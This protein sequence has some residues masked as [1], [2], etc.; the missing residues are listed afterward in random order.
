MLRKL[1]DV[2]KVGFTGNDGEHYFTS[3]EKYNDIL[4]DMGFNRIKIQR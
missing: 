2:G 3:R 4:K 1:G